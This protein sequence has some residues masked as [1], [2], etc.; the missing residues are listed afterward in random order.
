MIRCASISVANSELFT[1]SVLQFGMNSFKEACWGAVV[2][3]EG[4]L[5]RHHD[6]RVDARLTYM[7]TA[8][9]RDVMPLKAY[10]FAHSYDPEKEVVFAIVDQDG[11]DLVLVL[12]N[13]ALGISSP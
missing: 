2:I 9:H 8:T 13:N 5:T 11:D 10:D 1:R 12:K 6:G 3:Q 4:D 7:P